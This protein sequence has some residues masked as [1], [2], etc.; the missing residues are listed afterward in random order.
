MS[1]PSLRSLVPDPS[2]SEHPRA[3]FLRALHVER[4]AKAGFALGSL[5][6]AFVFAWFV[7]VPDRRYSVVLWLMLAFVLAVGTGLLLT[8]AFTLGSAYRL[9][10][11]MD[12]EADED[13]FDGENGA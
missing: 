11:G 5:L 4:N 13:E 10:R 6:A 12:D 8:V 9:V 7:Y 1:V 2:E 3:T